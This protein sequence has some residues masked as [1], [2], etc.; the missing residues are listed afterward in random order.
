MQPVLANWPKDI[1][2]KN[3]GIPHKNNI[4]RYGTK[5]A[6]KIQQL[7]RPHKQC[8]STLRMENG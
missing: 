4:K 5:N 3:N 1:S 2:I 8:V 7:L 6:P